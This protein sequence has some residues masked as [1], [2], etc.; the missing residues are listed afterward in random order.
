MTPIL[1]GAASRAAKDAGRQLALDYSG[2][3]RDTILID[4]S[5]W[6]REQKAAGRSEVVLES[7]R[8][9]TTNHPVSTK[10]WGALPRMAC[11]A[12]LIRA[13]TGSDGAPK[14]RPAQAVR[15]RRHPVRVWRAM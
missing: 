2:E 3:W 7:F 8:A 15:T 6:L 13:A 10:A 5:R 9:V 14:Y 1:N 11:R 4:L 12:G